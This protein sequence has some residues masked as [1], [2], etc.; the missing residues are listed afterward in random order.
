MGTWSTCIMGSDRAYDVADRAKDLLKT[1]KAW[2][3]L[4]P[5]V[6]S[7]DGEWNKLHMPDHWT[8]GEKQIIAAA[9]NE[10]GLDLF[11]ENNMLYD[12]NG[13]PKVAYNNIAGPVI[14]L[15]IMS[16]GVKMED[17]QKIA[18]I[19]VARQDYYAKECGERKKVMTDFSKLVHAYDGTPVT[20]KQE[21]L[22][23]KVFE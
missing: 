17:E 15:L 12:C 21:G 2:E 13:D 1:T 22:M 23:D 4:M 5:E 10:Y 20:M 11:I 9:I 3:E 6:E 7:E 8:P 19:M 18:F 16:A 14:G